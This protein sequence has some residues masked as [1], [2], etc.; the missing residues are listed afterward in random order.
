MEFDTFWMGTGG[1][2]AITNF[3][4]VLV[5]IG[6]YAFQSA[7]H[8]F[9]DVEN[10]QIYPGLPLIGERGAPWIVVAL[11]NML[12]HICLVI[13]IVPFWPVLFFVLAQLVINH[14][15]KRRKF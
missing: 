10:C 13:V 6:R 2:L 7:L 15:R 4:F 14:S 8:E 12:L 11:A 5:A 1:I 3:I 9:P